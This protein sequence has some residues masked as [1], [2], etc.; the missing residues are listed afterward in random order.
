MSKSTQL[1]NKELPLRGCIVRFWEIRAEVDFFANHENP[2]AR[3]AGET[4]RTSS[5]L[6]AGFDMLSSVPGRQTEREKY[7][8][9]ALSEHIA[10]T[11]S[12]VNIVLL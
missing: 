11:S 7:F 6:Y 4:H 2:R 1:C 9:V 8:Q 10:L 3:L 5:A 12:G